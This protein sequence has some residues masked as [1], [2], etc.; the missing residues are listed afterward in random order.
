VD[1]GVIVARKVNRNEPCPCGSGKKYKKCCWLEERRLRSLRSTNREVMQEAVNWIALQHGDAMRDWVENVWFANISDVE[2]KGLSTAEPAMRS[3]HDTNV[4]E[5][6][7]AEGVFHETECD[8]PVIDLILDSAPGIAPEQRSY[9][10]QLRACP[11]YLYRVERSEL[12]E[13]FVVQQHTGKVK[14]E[15]YIED[16]WASRMLDVG[17]IVGLRLVQTGGAWETTG[18]V[19]HIPPEYVE[20]LSAKLDAVEANQYSS[21]LIHYWL[22]LVAAHV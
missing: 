1:E 19:Y 6:M 22:G 3:I 10:E 9:L 21:S 12:G 20:T 13:G 18:A 16:K 2:R 7:L 4:V 14:G 5:Y 15:I 8:V 11:L 17:D